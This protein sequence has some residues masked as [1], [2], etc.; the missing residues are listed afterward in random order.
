MFSF[1]RRFLAIQNEA[2]GLPPLGRPATCE[3]FGFS[4]AGRPYL[5][6]CVLQ[7]MAD[8]ATKFSSGSLLWTASLENYG[9]QG[10]LYAAL[11]RFAGACQRLIAIPAVRRTS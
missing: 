2:P 8:S 7:L 5:T 3:R 11:N 4:N 10:D 1:L 6:L 9:N